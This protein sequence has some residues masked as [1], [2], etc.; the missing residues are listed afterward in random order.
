MHDAVALGDA[1]AA[2]PVHA[3]RMDLVEIRQRAVAFGDVADLADRRDV[4]VHR[5]NR[6][7]GDDLRRRRV[8]IAKQFV[9]MAHVVVAENLLRRLRMAYALDHRGVVE[10]VGQN[11]AAGQQAAEGRKGGVVR[12][13]ARGEQQRRLLAVQVG[14]LAFEQHVVVRRPRD[15]ARAAGPGAGAA[16]RVAHGLDHGRVLAHAEIVVR[17][18]DDDLALDAA[19]VAARA[20]KIPGAARE[21]GE[22]AVAA[23]GSQRTERIG[24]TGFVVHGGAGVFPGWLR[25]RGIIS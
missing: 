4:A 15:V 1:A 20:R 23:L 10:R 12:D 24:E 11:D 22:D 3:D 6:L 18:P 16:H 9:E 19:V 25:R 2:R 8:E 21:I 5:I 13:V 14:E 7:E 17:A